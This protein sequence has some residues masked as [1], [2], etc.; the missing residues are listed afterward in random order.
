MR[1]CPSF[2]PLTHKPVD[3]WDESVVDGT[4]V[5]TQR[6]VPKTPDDLA[7]ELATEKTAAKVR[8]NALRR[9]HVEGGIDISGTRL[10]ADGETR[11][12]LTGALALF[13]ANPTLTTIDW[14]IQPGQW[15]EVDPETLQALGVA[16]GRHVQGCF[17]HAREMH[18]AIDSAPDMTALAA[19][20]LVEGWPV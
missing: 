20:D 8:V 7:A 16:V 3:E 5:L 14:E 18:A 2:N 9:Q 19:I 11:A 15:L 10:R 1:T 17:S 6:V 4:L 12:N 13:A